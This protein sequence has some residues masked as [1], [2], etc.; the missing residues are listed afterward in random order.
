MAGFVRR[1]L[2]PIKRWMYRTGRPGGLARFLNRLDARTYGAG[3]LSPKEA[4]TLEVVGRTSGKV[5]SLPVVVADLNGQRY[6]VSMLGNDA[7]WVL[8]VRA[9]D[10]H[11]VLRR[12][13]SERVHLVDVPVAERAPIIK[14]YLDVAPGARPHVAVE[15]TAPLPEIE[16]IAP[17]HAVF[18]VEPA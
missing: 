17:D 3:R 14:R 18:R 15:R 5:V 6:L 1:C 11:A 12:D 8:N 2:H 7:N 16:R 13:G 10:G 9:A 4:M